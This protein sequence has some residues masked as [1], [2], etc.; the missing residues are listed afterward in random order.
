[1][2]YVSICRMGSPGRSK[3]SESLSGRR[4]SGTFKKQGGCQRSWSGLTQGEEDGGRRSQRQQSLIKTG[5]EPS[6]K[7]KSLWLLLRDRESVP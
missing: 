4:V 7:A 2:S 5:P 3:A 1:M 6:L